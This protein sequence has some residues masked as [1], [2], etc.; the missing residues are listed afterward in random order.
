MV[1]VVWES[2]VDG[3][4]DLHCLILF[5]WKARQSAQVCESNTEDWQ[6]WELRVLTDQAHKGWSDARCLIGLFQKGL[7]EI[8]HCL[9]SALLKLSAKKAL[10]SLVSSSTAFA[11]SGTLNRPNVDNPAAKQS[12]FFRSKYGSMRRKTERPF[13]IFL[14]TTSFPALLPAQA[15]STSRYEEFKISLASIQSRIYSSRILPG[16][17]TYDFA[18]WP[19]SPTLS[20][21]SRIDRS[22]H[23]DPGEKRC[24]SCD[25]PVADTALHEISK[26]E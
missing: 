6:W 14:S 25:A 15:R 8:I 16:R 2:A 12:L 1:R 21:S 26:S 17:V 3:T 22:L 20:D 10:Q 11:A 4:D 9:T 19:V 18:F 24:A 13:S 7:L 23:L 5:A